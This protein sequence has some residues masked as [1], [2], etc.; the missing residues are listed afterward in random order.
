[1]SQATFYSDR[2]GQPEPRVH[3]EIPARVWRGLVGL[4]VRRVDDGSF[5]RAFSVYGCDRFST[6]ITGTDHKAFETELD[7]L[8][9]EL[10]KVRDLLPDSPIPLLNARQ[11][12]P[13]PVALDVVDFV[14]RYVA[15]PVKRYQHSEVQ[16]EHLEFD[17]PTS[18]IRGQR[19]F[20]EEVNLIFARNGIAFTVGEDM[21]A[22]RIGPL[23]AS[24]LLSELVLETGDGKLDEFLREAHT[25]F[26]SPHPQDRVVALER[27]WKAFERLKTLEIPTADKRTSAQQLIA[28][29]APDNPEFQAHLEAEFGQLTDIG[30]AFHIR[31]SEVKQLPLPTP[32]ETSVDYLFTR[33]LSLIAYLLRQTDRM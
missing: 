10:R 33:L 32:T 3:E 9:P 11:A 25:R 19:R 4:V 27:L 15:E 5:A 13:T 20:R 6:A 12:P 1:M 2:T 18:R 14:G 22:A 26:L 28:K 30:N 31:H 21:K 23:E 17:Q 29:A 24:I 16:H 7:T 8:I